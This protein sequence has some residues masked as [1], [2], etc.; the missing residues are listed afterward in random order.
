M[1]KVLEKA[2]T[3]IGR[4]LS[5]KKV[6]DELPHGKDG[7]KTYKL[8]AQKIDKEEMDE[9]RAFLEHDRVRFKYLGGVYTQDIRMDR[10]NIHINEDFVIDQVYLG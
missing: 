7:T 4:K 6:E 8:I 9:I 2:Q 3:L 5:G 10:I 1:I